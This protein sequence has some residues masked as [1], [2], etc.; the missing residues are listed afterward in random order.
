MRRY[1][2]FAGRTYTLL[3]A[4]VATAAFLFVVFPNLPINGEMLDMKPGYTHEEAMTAMAQYGPDG[5]TTYAWG[6][7]VLDTLFPLVYVTLFA[8]LIYRFRLTDGT[9]WL[10][11]L[12]VVAGIWDL[13]EN[14]QITAMLVA[15][16]DVGQSQAALASAFTTVKGYIGPVYQLLGI[17]L[18]L[19]A[20]IRSGM[21]RMR[22]SSP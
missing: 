18:L 20:L 5:R 16:P 12:P 9:W 19:V 4:F 11:F 8:G 7:M 6:S 21:A 14:V 22:R 15:Y 13:M 17:G 1:F 10:A 2:E 3:A